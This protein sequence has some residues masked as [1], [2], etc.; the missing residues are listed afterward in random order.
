MI[1]VEGHKNLVRD[2]R[3]GAIISIGSEGAR[4]SANRARMKKEAERLNEL[5]NDVSEIKMMLKQ[6]IER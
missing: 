1:K 6:L 4:H 2:P 3:S 5:E